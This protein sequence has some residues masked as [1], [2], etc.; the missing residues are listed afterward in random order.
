MGKPVLKVNQSPSGNYPAGGS[1]W[2][3]QPY[4]LAPAGAFFTPNTFPAA[5]EFNWL[6]GNLG[7]SGDMGN[8][9][10]WTGQDAAL[11]WGPASP[12]P[13]SALSYG[14]IA[15]DATLNRW[16]MVINN[17]TTA[18]VAFTNGCDTYGYLP[19]NLTAAASPAWTATATFT[20]TLGS[21][22][23][24]AVLADPNTSGACWGVGVN[25]TQATVQGFYYNGSTWTS[26]FTISPSGTLYDVELCSLGAYVIVAVASSVGGVST[27]SF[28]SSQNT[29]AGSWLTNQVWTQTAF[30]STGGGN[31][32]PGRW[33][34]KSNG[35][36][37]LAISS[38]NSVYQVWKTTD[39]HTW[40]SNTGLSSVL[41][42]SNTITG[43]CWTQDALGA[44]WLVSCVGTS[45]IPFFYR[46]VDGVTWTLQAGGMTTVKTIADMDACGSLITATLQDTG[47]SNAPSGQVWSPDGG[48]TW[49]A[50]QAGF[51]TNI[52]NSNNYA[53]R[54]RIVAS[55]C[56]F[57]SVNS[58]WSR[59][60][61]LMGTGA[62]RV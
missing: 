40:A 25:N 34:L 62:S 22:A 9:F 16:L 43:L 41:A 47:A 39:G 44:C 36:M 60:S 15:W 53:T 14:G 29:P 57:A 51:P 23:G 56:G 48:V 30:T 38:Q 28:L 52:A 10:S 50:G 2:S 12:I 42:A 11:D 3:S 24:M 8:V 46:S 61:S 32:Y 5:E 17:G 7:A 13:G 31:N 27:G 18:W 26:E 45:G 33:L 19:S 21:W 6:F 37:A 55:G 54:S 4:A 35:S 1:S 20:A 58:L 59:F 49:Y